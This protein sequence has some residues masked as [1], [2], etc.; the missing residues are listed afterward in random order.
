M[1]SE[2]H[3]RDL[4]VIDEVTLTLEGGMTALTGETG[5]GKTLL[6]GAI[7][8]LA[9]GRADP[10]MV[11]DGADEAV[12]EGR[13]VTTGPEGEEVETV[14][15]RVVPSRG[16]SRASV[17][18]RLC[19]VAELA[20]LGAGVVDLHGQHTHQALL[21]PASHRRA[22][23]AFAGLDRRPLEEAEAGVSAARSSLAALG[24]DASA[25]A[26]ELELLR[27][28][29][30]ELAD[31][32]VTGPH[33]DEELAALEDVLAHAGAQREA[34]WAAQ[35]ALAGDGGALE[36]LGAASAALRGATALDRL[37]PRL[38]GCASEVADLAA[39]LRRAAENLE[40]DPDRLAALQ[41]RR[42]QLGE[43]RRKY[44]PDL[45]G[46]L[47][48][49]ARASERLAE[50][51]GL[52]GRR[53]RMEVELAEAEAQL[54][55]RARELS[56]ARRASAGALAAAVEANLAE[57]SMEAATVAVAVGEPGE[58]GEGDR[59]GSV[60]ILLA[61]NPGTEPL[62]LEK[63]ASGGE[64]ARFMLALRLALLGPPTTL[65][66]DPRTG[67]PD[68]PGTGGPDD[69]TLVF[70]EV[71]AG[72]GGETAL[73]VGRCLAS[74]ARSR[75]PGGQVLVVTHLAQVAAFADHQVAVAKGPGPSGSVTTAG[76][77]T[78]EARRVELSRMLSGQP[79]S[80]AARRHAGALLEFATDARGSR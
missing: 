77:V 79:D 1:L 15:R 21:S 38:A 44:G 68:D 18:G 12:V 20:R 58:G 61:A 72:I 46:V 7:E 54:A 62:P 24:G 78:G 14:L 53:R 65:V 67:G 64:L 36:G 32:A 49:Q 56:E 52:G 9:G 57:L 5:A 80:S 40:D 39:E 29:V 69:P 45:A 26:R 30:A 51:E 6:V 2:L 27:F 75:G 4:G 33:E 3:V 37:A 19:T 35:A 50:L 11:R 16:R 74:L 8:L 13:F 66:F 23:D 17:D 25:A 71:D 73:A 60:R 34:A 48:H 43:L 42:R 31:A 10:A 22:L 59:A 28:Q 63:V 76:T 70:D 41:A 55:V 47:D